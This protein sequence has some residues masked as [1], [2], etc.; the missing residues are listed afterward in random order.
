MFK[1]VL[2]P[3]FIIL[4]ASFALSG[5]NHDAEL[6]EKIHTKLEKSAQLE[7]AF[8]QDQQNLLKLSQKEKLTYDEIGSLTIAQDRELKRKIDEAEEYNANMTQLLQD[9]K[10]SF[11]E[12]YR[13]VL[14]IHPAVN[15][16]E[17]PEEKNQA[18]KLIKLMEK[19]HDEMGHYY[20][21]YT[22]LLQLN[23][24][25]YDLIREEEVNPDEIDDQIAAINQANNEML[26]TEKQ[27]NQYTNKYNKA[28]KKYTYK[29]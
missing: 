23:H 19:R 24:G 5:C 12:A 28:K 27:F 17:Q 8:T 1:K 16:I 4:M 9:T 21:Q 20:K 6:A 25:L 26:K 22:E 3:P 13:Q 29:L 11:D 7:K 10:E 2:A 15:K 14:T 18:N